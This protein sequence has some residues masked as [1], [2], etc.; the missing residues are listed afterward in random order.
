MEH[1]VRCTIP[2]QEIK[3][4]DIEFKVRR[5]GEMFGTLKISKGGMVWVPKDAK[6]GYKVNWG[7]F[8]QHAVDLQ[9]K[10]K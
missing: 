1:E 5:N 7:Q 10:E 3:N 2:K 8:A 6:K 4:A 9:N